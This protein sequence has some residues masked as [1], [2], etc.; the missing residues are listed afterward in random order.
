[1]K[2]I[3]ILGLLKL[4]SVLPLTILRGLGALVG[5]IGLKFSK[6]SRMR[7][8]ANLLKTGMATNEN[9]DKMAKKT[10]IEFGRTLVETICIAW[11]RSKA[12]NAS[13]IL[14]TINFRLVKE[15]VQSGKA[16]VFL[17]P[18]IGN[19]EIALKYTAQ[20]LDREFTVLYKPTKDKWL[21]ALMY[22]GRTENNI[23]PVPTNRNGVLALVK[24]L[25]R[26]EAIGVLPDSV[27]SQ[28]DGVWVNFF[29]Q[30]VFA[31]TLAA[32]MALTPKVITFVV[33][34][35][36]I[37]GGF[38]VEYVPYLVQTQEI[39]SLVQDLYS[40]FEKIVLQAPEQYYWS[41][42]RFRIPKSQHSM[43]K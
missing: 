16:L 32:K 12:Y 42:D 11:Q 36:R 10:A 19:F 37:P 24:A 29:G 18:H 33:A 23:H 6:K 7:L 31:T 39:N 15:A 14:E 22:K 43:M 27:A 1:M 13:L 20:K 25:K 40:I 17:T 26:K 8:R 41:Y 21:N 38:V 34:S 30:K 3:I 28:G 35:R 4:L 5:I 9:I 2:K